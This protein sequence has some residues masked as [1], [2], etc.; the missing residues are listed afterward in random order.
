MSQSP[1][2]GPAGRAREVSPVRRP[3]RG[4]QAA[5][6]CG[7]GSTRSGDPPPCRERVRGGTRE[8]PPARSG[9]MG[10]PSHGHVADA[11]GLRTPP[12]PG[13]A[14]TPRTRD[15]AMDARRHPGPVAPPT[16]GSACRVLEGEAGMALAG[17]AGEGAH[18]AHPAVAPRAGCL[19][20]GGVGRGRCS[21]RST[22]TPARR[23]PRSVR[24]SPRDTT[25]PVRWPARSPARG[26]RGRGGS[27]PGP[28]RWRR[29]GAEQRGDGKA[30]L[31]HGTLRHAGTGPR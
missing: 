3:G 18:R 1:A 20:P 14:L 8:R 22:A 13:P 24:G 5:C 9:E 17:A 11:D 25:A 15:H 31:L 7:P 21:G 26:G 29:Q 28:R 6:A 30:G 2:G 10:D 16:R 23:A 12:A 27:R 19:P 4:L